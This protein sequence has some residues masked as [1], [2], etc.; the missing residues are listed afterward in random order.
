MG[1]CQL[2]KPFE[3]SK[4]PSEQETANLEG[5]YALSSW[6]LLSSKKVNQHGHSPMVTNHLNGQDERSVG[7]HLTLQSLRITA[8]T[9]DFLGKPLDTKYS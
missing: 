6:L 3:V 8:I 7:S 4:G 9:E 5:S 2:A 1:G